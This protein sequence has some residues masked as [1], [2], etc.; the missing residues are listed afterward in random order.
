MNRICNKTAWE[1]KCLVRALTAQKLLKQKGIGSTL[2]LGCGYA[3]DKMVAHAWLRCGELYVTGGDGA[4]YA[5]GDKFCVP[6]EK[7]L[8]KYPREPIS[9]ASQTVDLSRWYSSF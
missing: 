7:S 6:D 3:E 1:S 4:G 8:K 2:Y 5:V 9:A